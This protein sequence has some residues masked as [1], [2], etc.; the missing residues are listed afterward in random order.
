MSAF[1]NDLHQIPK[2]LESAFNA[3]R[4]KNTQSPE[5]NHTQKK[6]ESS[7]KKQVTNVMGDYTKYVL[8][9]IESKQ[10]NSWQSFVS[11]INTISVQS[12]GLVPQIKAD[13]DTQNAYK[14]LAQLDKYALP[15]FEKAMSAVGDSSSAIAAAV[16]GQKG[17]ELFAKKIQEDA[18][19]G[20]KAAKF[21]QGLN[22]K[23]SVSK[24]ALL[25]NIQVLARVANEFN[26]SKDLENSIEKSPSLL[27]K[28]LDVFSAEGKEMDNEVAQTSIMMVGAGDMQKKANVLL[29]TLGDIGS[30]TA[31]DLDKD[32]DDA[33]NNEDLSNNYYQIPQ[34]DLY[35]MNQ[36]IGALKGSQVD[37]STEAWGNVGNNKT[38]KDCIQYVQQ[39]LNKTRTNPPANG[40]KGYF[41]IKVSDLKAM[42]ERVQDTTATVD[43]VVHGL[44]VDIQE[45]VTKSYQAN[46]MYGTF[47]NKV[48]DLMRNLGQS[49]V[50]V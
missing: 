19:Q 32:P 11:D 39:I 33:S 47:Q 48:Y 38:V 13:T 24:T 21:I 41:Y 49:S 10:P 2:Q 1:I 15:G 50:S 28:I 31:V 8:S 42:Q 34:T 17:G 44:S 14:Y 12:N 23:T 35:K 36:E 46:A 3:L 20:M 45:K 4:V 5:V 26:F 27:N 16:K 43:S 18:V 29:E 6:L 22:G 9:A 30:K 7:L 40:K 37:K 25:S